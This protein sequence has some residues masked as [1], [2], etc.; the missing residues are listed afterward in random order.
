MATNSLILLSTCGD[1]ALPLNIGR[2][3]TALT[4]SLVKVVL[5]D[6]WGQIKK[7]D[8]AFTLFGRTFWLG[9]LSCHVR[10]QTILRHQ[11]VREPKLAHVMWWYG[12]EP[13]NQH[14]P[15]DVWL[16]ETWDNSSPPFL[17]L[18]S[19]RHGE[20]DTSCVFLCVSHWCISFPWDKGP[21]ST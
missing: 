19:A 4:K 15:P 14:Q 7:S 2:L 16:H 18:L 5:D 21:R 3:V 12:R 20:I 8:V 10:C 9:A 6:F 17:N 1:Q 13:E 11:A